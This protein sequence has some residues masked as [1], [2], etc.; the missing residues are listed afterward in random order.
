MGFIYEEPTDTYWENKTKLDGLGAFSHE[1]WG[2]MACIHFILPNMTLHGQAATPKQANLPHYQASLDHINS[3]IA[4]Y[5]ES[6]GTIRFK[7]YKPNRN[8]SNDFLH[9]TNTG[10]PSIAMLDWD[11][12]ARMANKQKKGDKKRQHKFRDFGT[13]SGQCTTRVGSDW[14]I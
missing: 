8:Y 6:G 12:L 4:C 2:S 1:R 5:R 9:M 7:V 11:S 10:L 14:K 3:Q 13:T